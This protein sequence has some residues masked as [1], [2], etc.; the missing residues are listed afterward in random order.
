M[1]RPQ[2]HRMDR[3][4]RSV[5]LSPLRAGGPVGGNAPMAHRW[6]YYFL[7]APRRIIS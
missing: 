6:A 1:V 5:R 7:P 3:S 4:A 2:R